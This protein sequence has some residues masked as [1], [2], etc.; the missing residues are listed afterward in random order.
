MTLGAH[1]ARLAAAILVGC[2]TSLLALA[3]AWSQESIDV[4]RVTAQGVFAFDP[5][6]GEVI[7][8]EDAD[9][10]MPIGSITKVMTAL[11][12]MDHADLDQMVTIIEDDMVGPG[13]SAMVLTP[14]DTLTV[15]QLLTGLLVVS[16]GDAARALARHVGSDLAGT[17]DPGDAIDAFVDA[18][19]Q[20]ASD[21]D[22]DDTQFANPD[23]EDSDDAWSTAHDVALMFAALQG[24]PT[25][26]AMASE[27]SYEFTSVGPEATPYVGQ[28]T[29]QLAGVDGV[30]SAKT[31]STVEAGGCIVF[32]RNGAS[33]SAEIIAIL[34]SNLEYDENWVATVDERWTDAQVVIEAIDSHWTPGQNLPIPEPTSAPVRDFPAE[35]PPAVTLETD[36]NDGDGPSTAPILAATV[37]AGVIGLAGLLAWSRVG[38]H[39]KPGPLHSGYD[40]WT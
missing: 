14:G 39:R 12:V 22:L 31:G 21:L 1:V 16:G 10:R 6:T 17:G 33:G 27:V 37:A 40:T 15:E 3:P 23:G 32:A 19:N 24:N 30:T 11:V 28:S 38:P 26:S 9:T 8:E 25:L 2:L 4:P 36:E 35:N 5:A 18:M 34:G 20:K 7:L 29:N 13:Y